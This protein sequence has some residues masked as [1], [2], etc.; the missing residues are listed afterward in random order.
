MH[1]VPVWTH[2]EENKPFHFTIE[3][4]VVVIKMEAFRNNQIS[5]ELLLFNFNLNFTYTAVQTS[6]SDCFVTCSQGEF[7]LLS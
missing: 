5:L 2:R 6:P 3:M 7:R 4:F 1:N